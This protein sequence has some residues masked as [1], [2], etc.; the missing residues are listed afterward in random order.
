MLGIRLYHFQNPLQKYES[1]RRSIFFVQ[2][3]KKKQNVF[4]N[5]VQSKL[6]DESQ[7]P[8]KKEKRTSAAHQKFL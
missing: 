2:A 8:R 1:F 5:H 3:M 7:N 4:E 6:I